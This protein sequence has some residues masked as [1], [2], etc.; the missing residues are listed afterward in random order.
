MAFCSSCGTRM[1][2]SQEVCPNCGTAKPTS[3]GSPAIP[4]APPVAASEYGAVNEAQV[5]V[6]IDLEPPMQE[7]W[8]ILIRLILL[9]P[10]F[11]VGFFIALAGVFAAIGAWF[12]SLFTGRVPDGIQAFISGVVRFLGNIAA[13]QYFVVPE[14]PGI[15]FNPAP[16]DQVTVDIDHVDLNRAAVFFRLILAIPASIVNSV[17]SY[18]ALVASVVMWVWGVITGQENRIFHQ[19]MALVVRYQMRFYAYL[20]LLS[21]TQPWT[22]LLGDEVVD[23]QAPGIAGGPKSER[24]VVVKD[25]RTLVI[26][27]LVIGAVLSVIVR[28]T[29]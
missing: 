23:D 19:G 10:L 12:A 27:M 5:R 20:F 29:S 22:G 7:R 17:L 24:F 16:S 2:D 14:W 15:P 1:D 26:V 13:Y 21:P 18:G 3:G 4:F 8:T 6:G 9:I 11:I 25:A 28:S